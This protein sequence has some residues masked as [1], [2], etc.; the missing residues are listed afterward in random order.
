MS[1]ETAGSSTK[2][3]FWRTLG[4]SY[5]LWFLNLP[6]LMRICWLWFVVMVPVFALIN[7]W[8]AP[9]FIEIMR[10]A[11]E[12]KNNPDPDPLFTL[13]AQIITTVAM[14]PI[15]ASVA[16]AWHRLLLRDERVGAGAYFRLDGLVVGYAILLFLIGLLPMVPQLVA[17]SIAIPDPDAPDVS[18]S[19]LGL[20]GGLSFL[21][22]VLS[23]IGLLIAG[24]LSVI[25][26][27]RALGRAD[28]TLGKVWAATRKNSWRMFW[29][30]VLCVVPLGAT[31]GMAMIWYVISGA[32]RLN[33]TIVWTALSLFW[34]AVGMIGVGFLSLS[35][36]H[37]FERDR[38]AR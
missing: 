19:D 1:S 33:F 17:Q 11:A 38:A 13:S 22:L 14:L 18:M 10:L 24:R 9:H 4:D 32:S 31:V 37:F 5:K 30:Y 25:L 28:F 6:E 23:I 3:P 16:V 20:Y 15:G 36:R 35:Y 27:A 26:P 2:L 34:V 8:Q 7:W 12:G 21:L 29:G